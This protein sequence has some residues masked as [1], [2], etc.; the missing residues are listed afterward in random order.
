MKKWTSIC[1][2]LVCSQNVVCAEEIKSKAQEKAAILLQE[3]LSPA[4]KTDRY[5]AATSPLP[6]PVRRTLDELAV[7][8]PLS[9]VA[10]PRLVLPPLK[11]IRPQNPV[12][13]APLVYFRADPIL[14]AP[15]QLATTPFVRFPSVDVEQPI[16]LP[17]LAQ[18]QKDRASLADPT[19]DASIAATS[20]PVAIPR[21]SPKAH[22]PINLPDPFELSQQVRLSQTPDELPV[23]RP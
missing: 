1:L 20:K 21:L 23:P 11:S 4:G 19:L 8:M 14:P 17:I 18:P 5:I 15:I 13:D 22:P 10:P 9:V 16:P 12:E 7:P 2:V 6:R 3:L